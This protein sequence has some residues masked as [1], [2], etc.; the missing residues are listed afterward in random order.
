MFVLV[1]ISE[2]F[3]AKKRSTSHEHA[4]SLFS[5]ILLKRRGVAMFFF[6]KAKLR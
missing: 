1:L 5:N 2:P 3:V 4:S 6:K